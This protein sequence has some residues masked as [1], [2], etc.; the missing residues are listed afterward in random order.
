MIEIRFWQADDGTKFDDE[1]DCI[2]YERKKKLETYKDDFVFY[3][4]KKYPIP[5]EEADARKVCIIV[6][7]TSAAAEYIGEWFEEEGCVDPFDG[8][9]CE[10]VGTWVYGDVIDRGDEWLKLEL[11][12]E[13]LQTLI[14]EVNR[15]R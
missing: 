12:I 5:P 6:V 1:Y 4:Y 3:D 2:R 14:N 11:E 15:E 10:C 8:V 13:K 9:Y 7:K